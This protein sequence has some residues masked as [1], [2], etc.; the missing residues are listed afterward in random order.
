MPRIV[1][2]T[3]NSMSVNPRALRFIICCSEARFA[4]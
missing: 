3:T 4:R 2:T 1:I